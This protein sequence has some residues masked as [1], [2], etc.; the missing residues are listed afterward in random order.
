MRAWQ[1]Y[2]CA[3]LQHHM[4]V[5]ESLD[6]DSETR[7]LSPLALDGGNTGFG[8]YTDLLNGPMDHGRWGQGEGLEGSIN[9]CL[10]GQRLLG[11]GDAFVIWLPDVVILLPINAVSFNRSKFILQCNMYSCNSC[12]L[13]TNNINII[14]IINIRLQ[15]FT[16]TLHTIVKHHTY[17]YVLLV[18]IIIVSVV[19]VAIGVFTT[20]WQH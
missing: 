14:I 20:Q 1:G 12:I 15:N 9:K 6:G 18:N 17:R 3:G 13:E 5:I 4:L 16:Y 8:N 19:L 2:Q 10:R 11:D 7:R